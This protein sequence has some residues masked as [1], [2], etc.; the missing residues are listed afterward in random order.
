MEG[1][2]EFFQRRA[3]EERSAAMQSADLRVRR[4]H[5]DMAKRYD[6]LLH[7]RNM[8]LG[9]VIVTNAGVGSANG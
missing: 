6:Q 8:R 7:Q 1:D 9:Y 2:R 3:A 5:L 4:I